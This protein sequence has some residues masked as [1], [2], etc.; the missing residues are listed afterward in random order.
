[1]RSSYPAFASASAARA[2]PSLTSA[3]ASSGTATATV[4]R[5]ARAGPSKGA[6][7]CH[8]SRALGAIIAVNAA[9]RSATDRAIG[10]WVLK[11]WIDGGLSV[12]GMSLASGT[13]PWLGRSAIVPAH[14]DG[15]RSEPPR[16]LPSPRGVIP[17]ASATDSP[18][19][20][21]PGVRR[22]FHGLSV[23]P[24]RPLSV[25]QRSARS[26][27]LPRAIGIAPAARRLATT[28]A[29]R[30]AIAS[31]IG[32][33]P[34]V[35]A[36]PATSTFSLTVN[37]TPCSGP[38][39]APSARRRSAASASARAW[40][41]SVTR[42]AFTLGFTSSMRARWASTTSRLEISPSRIR[43]ASSVAPRRQSAPVAGVVLDIVTSCCG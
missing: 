24:A 8:G 35:V 15:H 34:H 1:M 36:E 28:G 18:A 29:S 2:T 12:G 10:P 6:G 20:E 41:A 31:A 4:G 32:T 11:N 9:R 7:V 42:S 16:S 38:R 17:V 39:G 30:G 37:G 26:G 25:C 33:R 14:C 23:G 43:A 5:P 40:S 3:A 13:R 27:R 19:L 22:G 21:P